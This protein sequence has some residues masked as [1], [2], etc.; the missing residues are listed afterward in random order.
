MGRYVARRVLQ[1]IPV[2]FGTLFLVHYLT[3]LGIQLNGDPVRAIFG[4]KQPNPST[5]HFMREQFHLDDPCLRQ[6]GNPC[7]GLFVDRLGRYARGDFGANFDLQP[8][9]AVIGRAWP[10]TVRLTIIAVVFETVLG[11]LSGVIAGLRKDR[12]ADNAVRVSTVFLVSIPV[13]V[14]GVLV[15]IF[16]GL[17][18]GLWVKH[19]DW[20]PHWLTYV[21]TVSYRPDHPWLSLIVPGLV[22]GAF[23]LASI[24][25]LTRTS[26]LE[27]IRADYVRTAKAK[28][29]RRRRVIGVHTL[30]NSLIAVVTYVGVDVG[31]LING[32]IVTEGIFNIPGLG[33]LTFRAATEGVVPVIIALVTIL[34]LVFLF[35]NLLVDVLY[36][37]LDPRIRY[38]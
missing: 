29:L 37:V 21:F 36:A 10:V 22:L 35:V 38:D 30:R 32:A 4:G 19:H 34:T 7:L 18:I 16:S 23:S 28:G 8:V 13:F 11:I 33:G 24:A 27:N 3:S 26:I 12:F 20:L 25:R 2:L 9:T 31:Y 17:Y 5:L 1:F 6:P 15:Q 14:L